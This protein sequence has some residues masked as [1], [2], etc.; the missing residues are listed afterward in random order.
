MGLK[1][2]LSP[3]ELI[4]ACARTGRH[5]LIEGP[6]GVGKTHLARTVAGELGRPLIRVDGDQ[7]YGEQKMTGWFDPPGVMAKGYGPE[8]FMAGPLTQA[9]EE[10][11]VLFINEL[12]RLP[13]GVQNLLLPALDEGML[14]IPRRGSIQAAPGFWVVATQ[15]PRDSI[16]T[17]ELSEALLDRFERVDLDYPTFEQE[18]AILEA[19]PAASP[20]LR[21]SPELTLNQAIVRLVRLTRE[22]PRVRRGVSLRGA[23][24]IQD[25]CRH[26]Y[27]QQPLREAFAQAAILA[28][29]NRLEWDPHYDESDHAV[30]ELRTALPIQIGLWVAQALGEEAVDHASTSPDLLPT[31]KKAP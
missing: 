12:N 31:K 17:V 11:A 20:E 9:M 21:F 15:N 24:A 19:R 22:S 5:V 18:C 25:L 28:L 29:P 3:A 23:L 2:G 8:S 13:E 30:V 4:R 16:A 1:A 10:G 7:R 27:C 26:F 6:V 14:A